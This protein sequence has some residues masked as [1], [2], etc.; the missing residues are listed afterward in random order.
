MYYIV[1]C[2]SKNGIVISGF[3]FRV[4]A[5]EVQLV[6]LTNEAQGTHGTGELRRERLELEAEVAETGEMLRQT[7]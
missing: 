5:V 3:L 6:R 2:T 7:R 4:R 1:K